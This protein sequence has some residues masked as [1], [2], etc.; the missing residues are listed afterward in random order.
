M[1]IQVKL[2]A[3]FRRYAPELPRGAAL[4]LEVAQG[5]TVGHVLQRLGIPEKEPLVSMINTLVC[6]R[7]DLLAEGDTLSLFPPMAG[8]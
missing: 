2:F 8:G 5:G 1:L 6:K 4:Q 7:D 3:T